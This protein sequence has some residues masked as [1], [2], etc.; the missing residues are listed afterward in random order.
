MQDHAGSRSPPDTRRL[1]HPARAR[2][3]A[4]YPRSFADIVGLPVS[5][6]EADEARIA[7]RKSFS[8]FLRVRNASHLLIFHD[9]CVSYTRITDD[10]A[11]RDR[12]ACVIWDNFVAH[13]DSPFRIYFSDETMEALA[14]NKKN[15][16]KTN[17]FDE[18]RQEIYE[19]LRV[20]YAPQFLLANFP[21]EIAAYIGDGR[22]SLT[23]STSSLGTERGHVQG[24]STAVPEVTASSGEEFA[25]AIITS[26]STSTRI[27]RGAAQVRNVLQRFSFSS[28][29]ASGSP[30]HLSHSPSARYASSPRHPP[31]T[32]TSQRPMESSANKAGNDNSFGINKVLQR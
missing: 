2:G 10:D 16:W 24:Q 5:L 26:A 8:E 19:R 13:H 1:G 29:T 3:A 28:G 32:D 9:A 12:A 27:A 15:G 31:P 6:V 4:E 23:S 7:W 14:M 21:A 30:A 18:A 17:A 25:E 20:T 22:K 11:K